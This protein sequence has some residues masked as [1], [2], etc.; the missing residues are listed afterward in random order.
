MKWHLFSW[1][2]CNNRV[3]FVKKDWQTCMI[4]LPKC[5][6]FGFSRNITS[7]NYFAVYLS[8]YYRLNTNFNLFWNFY[9]VFFNLLK[10]IRCKKVH[11]KQ[12]LKIQTYRNVLLYHPYWIVD[13]V[14]LHLLGCTQTVCFWFVKSDLN[15][16]VFAIYS[17]W[18]W[19]IKAINSWLIDH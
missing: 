5:F 16:I 11:E 17:K 3:F 6:L 15:S 2:E 13:A 10:I 18:M 9:L 1:Y 19:I 12:G 8:L 4:F 14:V 7:H